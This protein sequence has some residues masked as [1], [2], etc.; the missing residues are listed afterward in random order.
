[1]SADAASRLAK[2]IRQA[3]EAGAPASGAVL[4]TVVSNSPTLDVELDTGQFVPQCAG[5][6]GLSVG[7][8][9]IA[10]FINKGHDVAVQPMGGYLYSIMRARRTTVWGTVLFVANQG[11][12]APTLTTSGIRINQSGIYLVTAQN[13][14]R[15]AH[16]AYTLVGSSA[17]IGFG[18]GEHP[19]LAGD[20]VTASV[21]SRIS[22]DMRAP[23]ESP[24]T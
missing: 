10:H 5:P 21:A 15:T 18:T 11:W 20:F 4:G 7:S 9:V 3:V 8:R 17:D 2:A 12:A 1:M 16:V 6:T 13:D 24:A 19:M 23:Y 22:V 14:A